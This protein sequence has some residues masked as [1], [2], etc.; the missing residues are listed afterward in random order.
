MIND[1]HFFKESP[2][3]INFGIHIRSKLIS[4]IKNKRGLIVTSKNGRKRIENDLILGE[5]ISNKRH[6]WIDNINTNPSCED[7]NL[8]I[9]LQVENNYRRSQDN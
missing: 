3:D 9:Y 6:I 7:I 5:L 8:N 2:V 4:T 1:Y